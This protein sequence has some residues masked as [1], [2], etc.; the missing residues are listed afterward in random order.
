MVAHSQSKT[1]RARP[2]AWNTD[3]GYWA[4]NLNIWSE[5]LPN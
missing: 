1:V 3:K 4:S 5:T 2:N